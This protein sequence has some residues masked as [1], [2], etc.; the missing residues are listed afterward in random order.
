M[1]ITEQTS[2]TPAFTLTIEKQV[3]VASG[4]EYETGTY[5]PTEDVANCLIQF[6]DTHSTAPFFYAV[7]DVTTTSSNTTADNLCTAYVCSEQ[8][9]GNGGAFSSTSNITGIAVTRQKTGA[10]ATNGTSFIITGSYLDTTDPGENNGL[11]R[12]WATETSIRFYTNSN[13]R[14]SRAGRTYKWIAAWAPST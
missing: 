9:F 7:F 14:Y 5:T 11:P 3:P 8:I 4:L 13:S 6:S 10:N 2:S 1:F 12:Y